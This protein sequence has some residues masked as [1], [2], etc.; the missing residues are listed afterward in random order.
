MHRPDGATVLELHGEI[1]IAAANRCLPEFDAATGTP[2]ARVV[3]DLT[4]VTFFDCSGLRL[5]CRA[6]RRL[7]DLDGRLTVVCAQ[8]LTL[9]VLRAA[10]LMAVLR[11]V[12]TLEQ[13]LAPATGPASGPPPAPSRTGAAR[14]RP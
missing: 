7:L 6:H 5:L 3:V 2:G 10:R 8:P 1:D 4:H 14:G 11:P 13:A 12:A 9:R